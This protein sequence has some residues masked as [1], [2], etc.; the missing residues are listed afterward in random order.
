[1]RQPSV[2]LPLFSVLFSVPL[3]VSCQ[4]GPKYTE[5]ELQLPDQWHQAVTDEL[6]S[7]AQDLR[8]WWTVFGDPVLNSL[9]ERAGHDNLDLEIAAARV[10]EAR[11]LRRVVKADRVPTVDIAGEAKR[12]KLSDA[13]DPFGRGA[14][15]SDLVGLDASWELDVWGR[16]RSSIDAAGADIQATEEALRDLLVLL[17]AEVAVNYV[18][19]RTFQTR[20][21]YAEDNIEIQTST[22]QLANDRFDAQLVSALDIRQAEMNLARTQSALPSLRRG[23][24]QA[25]HRIA[26]LLGSEPGAVYEILEQDTPIPAG[27]DA[28]Q[29]GIPA[30]VLRRR[31]DIR[32]AERSLA[33]QT[34][35][36]G[37]AEANLY[38]Q[39]ALTGGFGWDAVNT[40]NLFTSGNQ[41]WSIG[42][43]FRWNVFDRDRIKGD[44][45]AQEARAEA[46]QAA[47]EQTVLIALEEVENA[48]IALSTERQRIGYLQA[49]VDAAQAA[50]SLVRELYSAGL[51]DFQPVLDSE[52]TL[53]EQQD[54]LASSQG[55]V[56]RELISLYTALGG[57]WDPEADIEA[58]VASD[59]ESET[60]Y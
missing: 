35:R 7:G 3:A 1:M 10:R 27:S 43:P 46:L 15:D 17:H 12:S 50:V 39:F 49:S 44:V 19:L 53:A 29:A 25:A 9:I 59:S 4:V 45:A 31:P 55:L 41:A 14:F 47:Y 60:T 40:T 16:V 22:L 18:D 36:I 13:Q 37:V 21:Q 5:P 56:A 57:G 8:S 11:A 26:V 2:R 28:V 34:L 30:E 23:A 42:I 52:Q 54:A 48:M 38:P 33:A 32:Q 58:L 6:E 24:A 20:M 51:E